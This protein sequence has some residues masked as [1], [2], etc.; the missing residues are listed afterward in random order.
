MPK[1]KKYSKKRAC[2]DIFLSLCT[3]GLWSIWMAYA[4]YKHY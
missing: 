2:L 3:G 1:L 4:R